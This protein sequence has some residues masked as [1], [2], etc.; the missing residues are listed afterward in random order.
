LVF[1][2]YPGFHVGL[3]GGGP[4]VFLRNLIVILGGLEVLA[5]K[6]KW[7]DLR[8]EGIGERGHVRGEGFAPL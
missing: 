8:G 5:C 4:R 6:C 7:V 1:G 2:F 3:G